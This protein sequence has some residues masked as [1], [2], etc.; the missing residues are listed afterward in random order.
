MK[1]IKKNILL[2]HSKQPPEIDPP[3]DKFQP[4]FP[5]AT[6]QMSLISHDVA[7]DHHLPDCPPEN[8]RK[9][10]PEPSPTPYCTKK[11]DFHPDIDSFINNIIQSIDATRADAL[12]F[13]M[14]FE[15]DDF[16]FRVLE[17]I[18]R[19]KNI[20]MGITRVIRDGKPPFELAENFFTI[21]TLCMIQWQ[22]PH[23]EK[24]LETKALW[25]LSKKGIWNH[26]ILGFNENISKTPPFFSF[27]LSN[28]N[29]AHS[30][31]MAVISRATKKNDDFNARPRLD[32]EIPYSDVEQL[33]GIPLWQ[34]LNDPTRLLGYL[35]CYSRKE[36][37]PMRVDTACGT[38]F[39][40]GK[41]ITFYFEKPE[42]LPPK[43]LDE[44]CKM[45]EA[46][47]SVA[48]KWVRYNLERA[49]LIAYAMENGVIVGNSSLKRP[50]KPFIERINKI[51]NMDFTHFLERGYTS[52][53]PEY[54]ALGVGAK[55][56]E[57]L[58]ARAEDHKIFSIISEDNTATQKIAIRN[59]TRKVVTY[60]SEQM[61]KPAGIWMPEQMI[62]SN[63][64]KL[65]K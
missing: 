3:L 7:M 40:L 27:V 55:L 39:S 63:M 35:T 47:G 34:A 30:H 19:K 62:N 43:Y 50:R 58:T 14:P 65:H 15:S 45:V 64:E 61:G 21:S 60:Y 36:L 5:P 2:I 16:L 12:F 31:E 20:T 49:F 54:R 26:F 46:G 53:R 33:P 48:T 41:D 10:I 59:K 42:N 44:I 57:G 24:K 18:H 23:P 38:I 17:A 29:I 51:S 4:I 13:E 1:H 52:V 9:K 6:T 22:I 8:S 32:M 56:L 28:P 11:E 25:Q 37:F